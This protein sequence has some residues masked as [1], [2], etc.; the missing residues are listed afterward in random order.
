MKLKLVTIVIFSFFLFF[1]FQ[2][3]RAQE[4]VT[5]SVSPPVFEL[6]A[7]PGDTLKNVIRVSNPHEEPLKVSVDTRNFVAVGEVGSV[8]LTEEETPYSLASWI[9]V[10]PTQV[11]IP[12]ESSWYF[13]VETNVPLNA[14]P[15][16][17]FGSVVFKTGGGAVQQTGAAVTQELGSLFL[18]RV[19]GKV[20]EDG[21]VE[22]FS[23]EK[24]FWEYGP[25]RFDLRVENNGN[26]HIKPQGKIA[27]TNML[28]KEV[29]EVDVKPQNVLPDA[30][31]KFSP[32]WEKEILF[33]KYTA[34]ASLVY[35]SD[36]EV[37]NA[38][39]SFYA[40]PYKVGGAVLAGLIVIGFLLYRGRRRIALAL[41]I[42]F[43]KHEDKA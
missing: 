19:S 40:F 29:A 38:T 21:R 4:M 22:S 27:I 14:E 3:A 24:K 26:V 43:G 8:G 7:N 9:S 28:G 41:R 25:I 42:L 16:G 23:A 1:P 11:E 15:G 12:G 31:R 2:R 32:T 10:T 39:T 17:H 33:G 30:V 20:T 36:S 13:N 37:L 34:T 35:G 6:T 18:L 5:L